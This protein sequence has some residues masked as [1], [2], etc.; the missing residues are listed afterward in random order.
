MTEYDYICAQ[1]YVEQVYNA[2]VST[3]ISDN[4]P[5]RSLVCSGS[6]YPKRAFGELRSWDIT[7]EGRP[8][9]TRRYNLFR[10]LVNAGAIKLHQDENT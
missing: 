3:H 9:W 7:R 4:V 1:N 10:E 6:H 5:I 2:R 8:V